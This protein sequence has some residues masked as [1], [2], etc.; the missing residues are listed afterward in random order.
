[1]KWNNTIPIRISRSGLRIMSYYLKDLLGIAN[2]FDPD[3]FI[4][5][6]EGKEWVLGV[7]V[8][9]MLALL[10]F[11]PTPLSLAAAL[12]L[13]SPMWIYAAVEITERTLGG[14]FYFTTAGIG[15]GVGYLATL[16]YGWIGCS[17]LVFAFGLRTTVRSFKLRN[18]VEFWET[19]IMDS[20]QKPRS[21]LNYGKYLHDKYE[22]EGIGLPGELEPL[23]VA[24]IQNGRPEIEWAKA[25]ANLGRLYGEAGHLAKVEKITSL[26]LSRIPHEPD[27]RLVRGVSRMREERYAEA[28][29][30]FRIALGNGKNCPTP[31]HALAMAAIAAFECNRLGD[32]ENIMDS[33][34]DFKGPQWA[35]RSTMDTPDI[36]TAPRWQTYMEMKSR[37]L[38][39]TN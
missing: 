37:E 35:A 33:L 27:C 28:L 39:P 19:A 34:V 32:F 13:A 29:E 7:F 22:K 10:F 4:A 5:E 14:R 20:P 21:I 17:A 8:I 6:K 15:L 38:V 11:A 9:G 12:I 2:A 30:D 18:H 26:G 24:L 16:G 1:M 23:L 3:D 31:D 36:A 25:C